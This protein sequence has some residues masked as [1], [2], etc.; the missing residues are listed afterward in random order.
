MPVYTCITAAK[1]SLSHTQAALVPPRSHQQEGSTVHQPA[2]A[3]VF[4]H[5]VPS[6]CPATNCSPTPSVPTACGNEPHSRRR[7]NADK[8]LSP[9][10]SPQVASRIAGIPEAAFS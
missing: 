5:V 10:T 1:T 6:S 7:A 4:V 8:V 9:K 3:S 2:P